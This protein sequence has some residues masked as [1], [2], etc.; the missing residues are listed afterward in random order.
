MLARREIM[1]ISVGDYVYDRKR[2]ETTFYSGINAAI[3][4]VLAFTMSV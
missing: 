4:I 1:F 3:T 2:E